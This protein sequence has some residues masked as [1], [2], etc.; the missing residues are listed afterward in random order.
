MRIFQSLAVL[1]P[2]VTI[3]TLPSAG[4]ADEGMWTLNNFPAEKV[5]TAYG[6]KPD[7][8]WLDHVQ[9][10]ALRL[11]SGCSA[12]F[13]SARGLVQTNHHCA[14][15]CIEQLSTAGK[16][17]VAAGFLAKTE[18]DEIRCPEIEANQLI[19]IT[20]VT[21]RVT[22]ATAGQN[23]KELAAALK[24]VR[25]TIAR[26]CAQ[27]DDTLRCDVVELYHG[28]LY[29]LYRYRRYQDVRLVFAPEIAIAFFGGDPDNFEFPRYDLDVSFLRVYDSGKPLDS[30]ASHFPYAKTDVTPGEVTFT[31]GHPGATNRDDTVTQLKYRRDVVLPRALFDL[32]ELR[33]LLT[34][35]S[36]KGAE[37]Q[38]IA[39]D[40]L[41]STEN[42]L[43]ALKGQ[44][45]ALLDPVLLPQRT[46]AEKALR[47][48]IDSRPAWKA[49]YGDAWDSLGAI[50]DQFRLKRDRYLYLEGG[51]GFRSQLFSY[52]RAI[53][54][55]GAEAQK[56]DQLRL[57][58]FT[59]ANFPALRQS[60]TS[61][62]P[63]YPELETL[64]LT[65]SLTK[66]REA[67]GPD[68]PFVRKVLGTRSPAQRAAELIGTSHLADEE[69][70]KRLLDGDPALLETSDDPMI[71]FARAIDPDLRDVR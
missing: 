19:A 61:T 49:D 55:H 5:E 8:A 28:G 36:T 41:F 52:A 35:F 12:S 60:L 46:T 11:A 32:S 15:R 24:A 39:N 10:S 37:Q 6:F 47:A 1:T 57:A 66:L 29:H 50:L 4:S 18:E 63:V 31:A 7:A 21:D 22:A 3:F 58:E 53:V 13:V 59:Q 38:R 34:E 27:G 23:G 56:P 62:H 33:G 30:R 44:F 70:R 25:A 67:L 68:D 54:R 20:D 65:F 17:F 16:D 71:V 9:R 2:L 42:S 43:K 40:L 26:D 69:L 51:S 14:H 45:A 48:K 64:T